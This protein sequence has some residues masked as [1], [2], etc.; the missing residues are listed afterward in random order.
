MCL[1]FLSQ[2]YPVVSCSW[3]LGSTETDTSAILRSS[4]LSWASESLSNPESSSV[5]KLKR[6]IDPSVSSV[7]FIFPQP[8]I[9][10]VDSV[11]SAVSALFR[12]ALQA[13][14][15]HRHT[16]TGQLHF[17]FLVDEP[18]LHQNPPGIPPTEPPALSG[19]SS[20]EG[21]VTP[22]LSVT[23]SNGRSKYSFHTQC[24][25]RSKCFSF[26]D[27][28][29]LS[30]GLKRLLEYATGCHLLSSFC[31]HTTCHFADCLVTSI[32]HFPKR[33]TCV[34]NLQHRSSQHLERCA[35]FQRPPG[36]QC[37]MKTLRFSLSTPLSGKEIDEYPR[38]KHRKKFVKPKK[39]WRPWW[40]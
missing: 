32:W 28:Y 20:F 39:R 38:I 19:S 3:N 13:L 1:I 4:E 6:P 15:S 25:N 11:S 24:I 21:I 9:S 27:L 2:L 14:L 5:N 40:I 17:Q 34:C 22:R 30:S 10:K 31:C 12:S 36:I 35:T 37:S 29:L 18:K 16:T 23:S 33:A 8:S 7:V 26:H